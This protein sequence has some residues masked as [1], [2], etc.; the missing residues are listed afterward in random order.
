MLLSS[1]LLLALAAGATA[2]PSS[3]PLSKRSPA[4]SFP[5]FG[6]FGGSGSSTANDVTNKAACKAITVIF[7]RGTGESGNVGSVI[8]PP[9]LKA[10]QSK[11]GAAKVAFQG[12][13]YPASAA[14]SYLSSHIP[15]AF[16]DIG[17]RA[18]PTEAVT[19][20]H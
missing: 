18:M 6:G 9:L 10:L 2:L 4:F 13:P 5:T 19:V 1:T 3:E 14:V 15:Y 16:I 17:C 12:V 7:A 11:V 20:G 8:G